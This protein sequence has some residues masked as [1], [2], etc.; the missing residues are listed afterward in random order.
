MIKFFRRIRRKLLAE[1][2]FS[3]YLLYATGEI[4]LVVIGIL[5]A[6][7]INNMNQDRIDKKNEQTY[8]QGLKKEFQTSK[9]KLNELIVVNQNNLNGAKQILAYTSNKDSLPA[10]SQF[11]KLLYETFSFDIGFNPNNSLLNEMI[12]SGSLKNISNAKLRIQLTNWI[13]TMEDIARQERDLGIQREKVLE[14]FRTNDN[15][16]SVVLEQAGVNEEL[17]LPKQKDE[18]SNLNLLHSTAFE[19]IM[20]MFILTSYATEDSHYKPLMEDLD[21]IIGLINDELKN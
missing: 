13:S 8:L 21:T 4:V 1:K 12:N 20:L 10:E 5:I 14:L 9:L 7:A 17:D 19:N 18:K 15:S 2:Q 3:K 6:L 16:L 11:S